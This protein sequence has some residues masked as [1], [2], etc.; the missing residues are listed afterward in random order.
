[1]GGTIQADS[2]P[3]RGSTFYVELPYACRSKETEA[4]TAEE[5]AG[6]TMPVSSRSRAIL[7]AEDNTLN[8]HVLDTML[9]RMGHTTNIASNG[10]QALNLWKTWPCDCILMDISMPEMDGRLAMA[11]IREQELK[12]G[13]HIPI[14][15]LTAHALM[16]ER[17]RF[18][19]E[20]FDGYLA[21]P[22]DIGELFAMLERMAHTV[23]RPYSA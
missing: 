4:K 18:L 20:G 12:T 17:E 6:S 5:L 8:A 16:G 22:V 23:E 9:R 13:S 7:I 10:L 3:G 11:A 15:A 1:M 19:A 2:S 21:K 14:I